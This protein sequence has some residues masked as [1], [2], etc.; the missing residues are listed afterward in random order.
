MW[1][2][3]F[4]HADIDSWFNPEYE[5][6]L[7]DS[8]EIAKVYYLNSANDAAAFRARAGPADRGRANCCSP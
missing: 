3:S 5:H 1:P 4:L 6:V 8:L 7:D 2:A